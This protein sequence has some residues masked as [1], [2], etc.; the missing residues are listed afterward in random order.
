M[1]RRPAKGKAWPMLVEMTGEPLGTA[2]SPIAL[3]A[4]APHGLRGLT[5][6]A[7][8]PQVDPWCCQSTAQLHSTAS[9]H[10]RRDDHVP[11]PPQTST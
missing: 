7:V 3:R 6:V 11:V 4:A 9:Q 2:Q 1:L 5:G 8:A 10:W